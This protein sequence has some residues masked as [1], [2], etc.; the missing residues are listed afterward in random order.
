MNRRVLSGAIAALAAIVLAAGSTTLGAFDDESDIPA[1]TAGAGVLQLDL[2]GGTAHATLSFTDIEPSNTVTRRLWVVGNDPASA[3]AGTVAMVVG[4]P[5][6]VPGPCAT[7]RGKALGD[8]ASGIGGCVVTATS[9]RGTPDFGVASRLLAF[10]VSVTPAAGPATCVSATP[11]RSV[12]PHSGPGNL[13]HRGRKT[14]AITL[15]DKHAAPIVLAPG[16]GVCVIVQASW[17]PD[18][19]DTAQATPQHPVD[20]A[21]QGDSTSIDVRFTLTQVAP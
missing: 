17:P 20:N 3:A 11:G 19:T 13:A 16:R 12:L 8:I 15:R 21:A 5:V 4:S 7:S 6:D 18:V 9:V 14:A 1:N 2:D 10:D